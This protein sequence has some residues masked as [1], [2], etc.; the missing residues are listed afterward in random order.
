MA[1][2]CTYCGQPLEN[3]DARF[4][5][6]CG[7]LQLPEPDPPGA[8]GVIK[9]R[10]PPK[11]ISRREPPPSFGGTRLE[12]APGSLPARQ[13]QRGQSAA[14]P[15]SSHLAKRPVRLTNQE[16][17]IADEKSETARE[18]PPISTHTSGSV[19][20]PADQPPSIEEVSTMVLPGWREELEQVRK[21]QAAASSPATPETRPDPPPLMPPAASRPAERTTP[22]PPSQEAAAQKSSAGD[23]FTERQRN[24]TAEGLPSDPPRPEL[25]IKVWEQEPTLHY[26][27]VQAG[28]KIEVGPAPA[29]EH[30]PFAPGFRGADDAEPV[31]DRIDLDRQALSSPV[32]TPDPEPTVQEDAQPED[33]VEQ[34]GTEGESGVEDLPTVPLAVPEAAKQQP[35]ITI[36]RSSTPAPKKSTSPQEEIEDLPT[37][38]MPASQAG[39]RSP[40]PP[41]VPQPLQD[42]ER[43]QREARPSSTSMVP[44][45]LSSPGTYR[46]TPPM[47]AA[48]VSNIPSDPPA[49]RGGL[50]SP[51]SQPGQTFHPA[52]MTAPPQ[53]PLSSPG[54][55]AFQPQPPV[56]Q[57]RPPTFTPATPPP[58]SPRS[59]TEADAA[60]DRPRKKRVSPLRVALLVVLVIVVGAGAFVF[61]YQSSSG[62][63]IAQPYQAFQNSTLGIFLTYPQGWTSSLDRAQTSVHFADSSQT[64]Q[65][66]LSMS[67][68]GAQSLTQYIDQEATQLGITAPQLE[69]TIMFGGTSWQQEQGSVVQKGVT[70]TLDLYATQHGAHIYTLIFMAPPPVYGRMERESFAPL[71]ASFRF[72]GQ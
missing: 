48:R 25:H 12:R 32:A 35:S 58:V 31:A 46:Q 40:L 68:P 65:V 43:E 28:K 63:A 50:P 64:G 70:Y 71:R 15:Q 53:G 39:P 41:A 20:P 69:P 30:S 55:T 62:G 45:P 14:A 36:E 26:P 33:E 5:S 10:L 16:S 42:R 17:L 3:E 60:P 72:I 7:R 57:Q 4:C 52:S 19:R 11:E 1:K 9:V 8:P 34:E 59:A 54:N 6:K 24:R 38:P 66:T 49:A 37:R 61:Y 51:N 44:D 27:Q 67:A 22:L 13:G 23:I 56:V 2:T 29:V 21:R 18:T 47:N